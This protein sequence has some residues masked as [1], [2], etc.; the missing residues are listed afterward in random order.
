MNKT[1]LPSVIRSP[2]LKS[3][4][5][6]SHEGMYDVA[7]IRKEKF[8]TPRGKVGKTLVFSRT[9]PE[10]LTKLDSEV[11]LG[12]GAAAM[13]HIKEKIKENKNFT[14]LQKDKLLLHLKA[15]IPGNISHGSR[16]YFSADGV[17]TSLGSVPEGKLVRFVDSAN[18]VIPHT[19][20]RG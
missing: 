15:Q 16:D 13:K 5:P 1:L 11:R 14:E 4:D 7:V 10:Q 12:S 17:S 8:I 3:R 9:K 18:T 20:I 2:N 6:T 19:V